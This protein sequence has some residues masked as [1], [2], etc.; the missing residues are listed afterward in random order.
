MANASFTRD[1]AVLAV[2]V[3]Y[4]SDEKT[5]SANSDSIR[6]LCK[7]LQNLPIHPTANRR[8][9]FRN[10]SGVSRQLSLFRNSY[11]QKKKDPNVGEVFYNVALEFESDPKRI[12]HIAEAIRKN[13]SWFECSFG[14]LYEDEGFPEGALLGH[15]HRIVERRDGKKVPLSER[16]SICQLEP[17]LLYKPCGN[18]LEQ[19]LIVDPCSIDPTKKYAV[20]DFITVCPNCHAALHRV[21]PWLNKKTCEA[22]LR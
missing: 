10:E 18:L 3:L 16:C 13:A 14:A 17:E 8:P 7:L 12:H 11:R 5:P 15:L 19:H 2:D 21:R 20:N 4:S 9:D 6:E 1:E 22:L